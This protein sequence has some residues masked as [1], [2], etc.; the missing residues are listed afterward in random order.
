MPVRLI[1]ILVLLATPAFAQNRSIFGPPRPKVISTPKPTPPPAPPVKRKP[2]PKP[3]SPAEE[4]IGSVKTA[5][6]ARWVDAA[7][8]LLNDFRT[9]SV[10]VVFKLDADAKVLDVKVTD[11]TSNDAFAKFCE[12]FVRETPFGKPPPNALTHGQIEVPFTFKIY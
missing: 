6:A 10:S 2:A 9:G 11:N 5:F 1:L 12:K 7:T 4:Y 8:P 3:K